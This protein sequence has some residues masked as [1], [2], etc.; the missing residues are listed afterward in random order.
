MKNCK[1]IQDLLPIYVDGLVSKE[2]QKEIEQH[3]EHCEECRMI[4]ER[5]QQ[6]NEPAQPEHEEFKVVLH[7]LQKKRRIKIFATL[8]LIFSFVFLAFILWSKGLF[9]IIERQKSPDGSTVTT[10][11]DC[12][13]GYSELP[14]KSGFTL[15]DEGKYRGRS[16]YE[17]AEFQ[18][19]WWSLHGNYQVVSMIANNE[20]WLA[21]T[22]YQRNCGVNLD[23]RLD[24]ALYENDFFKDV[25]YQEETGQRIIEFNFVQW[26]RKDESK[27]LIYF[28]YTDALGEFHEGYFWYDY[29]TGETYGEMEIEQG[30]KERYL[31]NDLL[32]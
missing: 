6:G 31:L 19:L 17:D 25:I 23:G 26:S 12:C 14:T 28:S 32:H 24:L 22:D 30:E 7:T 27:M 16:I 20:I 8:A 5:M 15:S 2:S 3:M 1:I 4:P 10:V 13:L 29:E 21:M 18:G 9:H 11:F